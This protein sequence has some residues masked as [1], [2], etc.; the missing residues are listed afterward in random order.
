MKF[1]VWL[2]FVATEGMLS[3]VPGPAVFFV[4]ATALSKGVRG[5]LAA[6][7]AILS[8]NAFYFAISAT[9]LGAIIMASYDLFFVIKWLG[10]VY[11]FYLGVNTFLGHGDLTFQ[12][13]PEKSTQG[14]LKIFIKGFVLQASNPKSI[15]F[16]TALLPQFI[17]LAGV[18]KGTMGLPILLGYALLANRARIYATRKR[19]VNYTNRLCGGLLMLTATTMALIRKT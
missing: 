13:E 15:L 19:F 5:S 17:D 9:S 6:N 8:A 12:V 18:L 10:A 14:A 4:L 16:F 3:L 1:E 11:L 2:L 7:L